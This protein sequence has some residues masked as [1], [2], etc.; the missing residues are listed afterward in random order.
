MVEEQ[1]LTA[2][3]GVV[4]QKAELYVTE[5]SSGDTAAAQQESIPAGA[6]GGTAT[7][8]RQGRGRLLVATY[9]N[10]GAERPEPT[11]LSRALGEETRFVGKTLRSSDRYSLFSPVAFPN[12]S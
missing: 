1:G 5:E 6:F 9:R 10:P 2:F 4:S 7:M 3:W 12:L 8:G 11:Y